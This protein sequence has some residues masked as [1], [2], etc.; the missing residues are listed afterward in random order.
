MDAA[1]TQFSR[2]LLAQIREAEASEINYLT[3]TYAP[4]MYERRVATIAAYRAVVNMI[5][6]TTKKLNAGE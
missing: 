1:D 5:E 4:Q 2:L 3:E 6:E